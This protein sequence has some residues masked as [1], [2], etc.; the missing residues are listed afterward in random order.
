MSALSDFL[1]G[2]II[3]HVFRALAYTAPTNM[4]VGLFTAAP[5]DTGGGTEVSGNAYTRVTVAS[6][7]TN[8]S[9]TQNSGTGASTGTGGTTQNLTTFTFPTPTPSGW[10]TVVAVGVFDA[11]TVGNLLWYTTLT[12]SKTINSGDVVD[13]PAG[14]LT[15]QVDN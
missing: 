15:F 3:D 11:A 12:V 6:G 1:E 13:F 8:W 4:Y 7:T 2:K 9:N 5:S 10:G 14:S